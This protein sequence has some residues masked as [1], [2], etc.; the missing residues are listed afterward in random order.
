MLMGRGEDFTMACTSAVERPATLFPLISSTVARGFTPLAI[1]GESGRT[2][3]TR[4][5]PSNGANSRPIFFSS[6]IKTWPL[7][8]A[9]AAPAA[10]GPHDTLARPMDHTA[11]R[12]MPV[13][14]TSASREGY[15]RRS[16]SGNILCLAA[17]ECNQP[18]C[19]EGCG[20]RVLPST[21]VVQLFILVGQLCYVV[22]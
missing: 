9:A 2:R 22:T 10:S 11:R 4:T 20:T 6:K 15:D 14:A 19:K 3:C 17:S 13:D 16:R 21:K 7:L 12:E 1:A 8:A 18:A 5:R